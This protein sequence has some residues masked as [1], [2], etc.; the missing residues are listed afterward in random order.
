MTPVNICYYPTTTVFLD[1]CHPF[2]KDLP[3]AVSEDIAYV[4]FRIPEHAIHYIND[5]IGCN[6]VEDPD[7]IQSENECCDLERD[8]KIRVNIEAIPSKIED[9]GRFFEPSVLVVDYD[10]PDLNGLEVCQAIKNPYVKKILLTGVADEHIAVEAL[11]NNIIDYY[12]KKSSPNVFAKINALIR[13]FQSQY[14]DELST[15]VRKTLKTGCYFLDDLKFNEYFSSLLND[16]KIVEYYFKKATVNTPCE[17]TMVAGSGAPYRL[18]IYN[19][20]LFEQHLDLAEEDVKAPDELISA[21]KERTHILNFPSFDCYYDSRLN[22]WQN[23]LLPV[24]KIIGEK[25]NYYCHFSSIDFSNL[26]IFSYRE[27]LIKHDA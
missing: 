7:C 19:D 15:V 20:Q 24:E 21:L 6:P 25:E 16:N 11:N 8:F 5:K 13:Q 2:L 3:L 18:T 14:F 10:M 4:P 27:H 9:K 22:D 26:S 1:D 12:I 23:Y 17:F